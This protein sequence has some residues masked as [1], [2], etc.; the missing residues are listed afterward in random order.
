[1]DAAVNWY[2][3]H[4]G[5]WLRDTVGLTILEEGVYRRLV[6]WYY[7][8][9]RP[10]AR[11]EDE[12]GLVVRAR[13][14]AE[15]IAVARVLNKF[16]ELHDDGWHH[17]R[18]DREIAK[19][20]RG[21][22]KSE[23]ARLAQNERQKASREYRRALFTTLRE[24]GC[25]P[26]GMS[27]NEQLVDLLKRAEL[28]VPVTARVTARVTAAVTRDVT[29]NGHDTLFPLPI[30]QEGAPVT[31]PSDQSQREP[32]VTAFGSVTS[33]RAQQACKAMQRVGFDD[34]RAADPRLLTLLDQ[35][36]TDDELATVASEAAARKLSWSWL[37]AVVVGRRKD[38]ARMRLEGPGS[39]DQA[40]TDELVGKTPASP[41]LL[42][43]ASTPLDNVG[44]PR[45]MP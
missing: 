31:D 22:P 18:C 7:T 34:V 8:Q 41:L 30:S 36:A 23:E 6:D 40:W 10:L 15:R 44:S 24:A 19:F 33:A 4:L 17:S 32:I 27:T 25:V 3:H 20:L 1:M 21:R 29:A 5:D 38:A 16:F 11:H 37:L 13:S 12:A 43:E 14:K 28:P 45:Q 26:S 2:E 42:E 39:D 9:E 35:G